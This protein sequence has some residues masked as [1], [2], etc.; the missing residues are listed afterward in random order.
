MKNVIK[1]HVPMDYVDLG[2]DTRYLAGTS[3]LDIP[4]DLE[5]YIIDRLTPILKY[6]S[7]VTC[8]DAKKYVSTGQVNQFSSVDYKIFVLYGVEDIDLVER[9]IIEYFTELKAKSLRG[10]RYEINGELK[11]LR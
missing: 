5:A 4:N 9:L 7:D 11:E 2:F 6:A 1:I 8:F 3:L 10:L